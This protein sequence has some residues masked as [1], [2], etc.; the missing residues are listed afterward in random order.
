MSVVT[1]QPGTQLSSLPP[2]GGGVGGL[3]LLNNLDQL[4]VRQQV[5]L[6]EVM[7]GFEQKNKY[8]IC[9][10]TGQEVYFLKEENDCC[11][12]NCCGP[13]RSFDF[14]LTDSTK[15]E[16]LQFHRDCVCSP[17]GWP[18]CFCCLCCGGCSE[19]PMTITSQG[20]EL[21]TLV[22]KRT[23]FVPTIEVRDAGGGNVFSIVSGFCQCSCGD[24]ILFKILT[25]DGE[26]VGSIIKQYNGFCMEVF[27]DADEYTINFPNGIDINKKAL[28]LGAA[29]MIDFL[30]YE[31][32]SGDN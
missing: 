24:E 13:N 9:N 20:M 10:S 14:F 22:M 23:F 1:N 21:G 15:Q 26:E 18:S 29:L 7:T 4:L 17:C 16:V 8:Q 6:C 5:E 27:T 32:K 3:A 19:Q 31:T 28:L 2:G 12:R 25:V 30:F 11:N